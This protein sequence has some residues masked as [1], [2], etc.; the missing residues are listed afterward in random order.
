MKILMVDDEPG[1]CDLVMACLARAGHEVVPATDGQMAWE[2]WQRDHHR[3][4]ITDW[5]MP[6]VDGPELIRRMRA[7]G[8]PAYTYLILLTVH[9]KT[10]YVVRGLEIGAD[11]YLT[12][13]FQP[14]ELRARVAVGERILNMEARLSRSHDR[15]EKLATYD[16]LTGLLNRWAIEGHVEAELNRVRR[17]SGSVSLLMVD[18]DHFKVVNDQHGHLL[19]DRA[20]QMV[21]DIMA[22]NKRP[23]DWAGRWGGEEFLIILPETVPPEAVMVAERVRKAVESARMALPNGGALQLQ[24]SVG[25]TTASAAAETLAP[26]EVLLR[27]ADEAL[28]AAKREGRNRVHLYEAAETHPPT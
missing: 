14:D 1:M 2:M 22:Q 9:E 25:V 15:M 11:D 24:V 13:P 10:E 6:R 3:L 21:A 28:Y 4:V 17:E 8:W 18:I 20:L 19:G 23:Y 27:Q 12:K 5:M 26:L 7:S 16:N